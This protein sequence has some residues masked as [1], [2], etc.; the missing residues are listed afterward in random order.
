MV[1]AAIHGGGGV[2]VVVA[3]EKAEVEETGSGRVGGGVGSVVHVELGKLHEAL[4]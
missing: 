4:Q 1:S 2:V 3:G